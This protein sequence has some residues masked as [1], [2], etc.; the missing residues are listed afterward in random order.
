MEV[1][2]EKQYYDYKYTFDVKLPDKVRGGCS[3]YILK[4]EVA[5]SI[6]IIY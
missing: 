6:I 1:N 3:V 5:P 4:K 2:S